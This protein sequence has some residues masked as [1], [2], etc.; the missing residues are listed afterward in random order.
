MVKTKIT[1][2][3]I[4]I[5]TSIIL[6]WFILATIGVIIMNI[7]EYNRDKDYYQPCL[8]KCES[9]NLSNDCITYCGEE[10]NL[11]LFNKW[12]TIITFYK[13]AGDTV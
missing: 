6:S 10:P 3:I 11:N 13:F 1:K 7:S 5:I 9:N 2:L 8:E 4:F 12:F